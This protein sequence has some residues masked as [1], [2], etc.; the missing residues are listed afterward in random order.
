MP[1]NAANPIP[2]KRL[3]QRPWLVGLLTSLLLGLL[4]AAPSAFAAGTDHEP[5]TLRERL[6]ARREARQ[7]E[8]KPAHTGAIGAITAPGDYEFKLTHQ[9]HERAYRVHVPHA[10]QRGAAPMPLVMAFHGGGGNMDIQAIDRFYGLITQSERS[11]TLLVF[12][13]GYSR[14]PAGKLATWNAG[15]CCGQARDKGIDDVGFVR[16][17]LADL[18]QRLAFDR[19]RVYAIGMSN[20]GMMTYRLACEMADTFQAIAS[21]A[22]TDGTGPDCRPSRPVPVLHI[23]AKDDERVLFNGGS[24]SA[25]NTHA[26]FVSVPD[27][28]RKWVALDDCSPEPR[29]VLDVPGA[30]CEVHTGCAGDAQVKLCVTDTGGH[31][32]PGGVKPRG[33]QAGS[34][35]ISANEEI[36]DFFGLAL[37]APRP[38]PHQ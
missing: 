6:K 9:G 19:Q 7:A 1:I 33:G 14:L 16:A 2:T 28:V 21:V 27:T 17:V 31:S 20:G 8:T 13:N 18:A 23:H 34:T 11:N 5:T 22:G 15:L 12:P 3:R 26:D 32:W 29:T 10:F 36:W 30:R 35:A 38:K 24:G 4:P 25:S 37:Q